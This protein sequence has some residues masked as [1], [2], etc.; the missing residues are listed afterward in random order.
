ML[1]NKLFIWNSTLAGHFVFYLA[2]LL[3]LWLVSFTQYNI[4][5]FIHAVYQEMF[6]FSLLSSMPLRG[7]GDGTPLQYSRLENPTDGGA[8]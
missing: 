8:W 1:F 4:L 6:P 5:R 2:M 3:S 7:E